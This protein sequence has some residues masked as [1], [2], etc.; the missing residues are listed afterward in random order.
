MDALVQLMTLTADT[1]G[2]I[3]WC[4]VKYE[5]YSSTTQRG[6]CPYCSC[7][8]DCASTLSCCPDLKLSNAIDGKVFSSID[9]LVKEF[10][11][12]TINDIEVFDSSSEETGDI[13]DHEEC[14]FSRIN[15]VTRNR[16][17]SSLYVMVTKCANSSVTQYVKAKCESPEI[18]DPQKVDI[19]DFLPVQSTSSGLVYRNK[20][21][22]ICNYADDGPFS[23]W[24]IYIATTHALIDFRY[25]LY[26]TMN[27][28][29][30]FLTGRFSMNYDIL[31]E[32]SQEIKDIHP[33]KVCRTFDV[34]SCRNEATTSHVTNDACGR[35]ALPAYTDV[36]RQFTSF[37]NLACM[38]CN[39][40]QL[41]G[42][43]G[44][45]CNKYDHW[46]TLTPLL[47]RLEH[48]YI[49]PK[50][51]QRGSTMAPDLDSVF[52]LGCEPGYVYDSKQVSCYRTAHH[53]IE[54]ISS[55]GAV[56]LRFR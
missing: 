37:K 7:D 49:I 27:D 5:N 15:A 26:Y 6:C 33:P 41:R 10:D 19:D 52:G 35:F 23:E 21:C 30:Q 34:V 42:N 39:G 55:S 43:Y 51:G 17:K 31:F 18:D 44:I 8:R 9:D 22:A 20:F 32:P 45:V 47:A 1:C 16:P 11:E 12:T 54:D 4:T 50:Y 24:D 14:I 40:L 13:G 56:P 25:D 53:K 36:D 28:V 29:I 48:N 3:D 46:E 38:S 2:Q